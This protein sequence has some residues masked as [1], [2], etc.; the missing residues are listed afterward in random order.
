MRHGNK[1]TILVVTANI[2]NQSI[3]RSAELSIAEIFDM[4]FTG[5]ASACQAALPAPSTE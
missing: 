3:E 5:S 1:Y 2:R 4:I